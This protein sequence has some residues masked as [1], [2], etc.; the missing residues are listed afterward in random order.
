MDKEKKEKFLVKQQD[1]KRTF[2][3]EHGK[4]VLYDLMNDHYAIR[5]TYERGDALELAYREGQ[6]QVVLRILTILKFE[7][8]KIKQT[9]VEAD[10]Y[11]K[12][13]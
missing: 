5:S 8:E 11:A 2:S 12:G 7:P 9:I 13:K 3:S 10:D 4:R 6:R 1:Y